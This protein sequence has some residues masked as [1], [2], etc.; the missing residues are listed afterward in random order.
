MPSADRPNGR[1][2][3]FVASVWGRLPQAMRGPAAMAIVDQ[4]VVSGVSFLTTIL[5]GRFTNPEQLGLYSLATSLV[6]GVL[7][8][9]TSLITM[10]FALGHHRAAGSD[11]AASR[12]YAGSTL[13]IQIALTGLVIVALLGAAVLADGPQV[14]LMWAM[15]L[16][17]PFLLLREFARRMAYAWLS[18]P[19]ALAIDLPVGLLQ[20][21]G[22]AAL[23]AIG[24]LSASG[25]MLVLGVASAVGVAI[26]ATQTRRQFLIRPVAF[27]SDLRRS[28]DFG[29]WVAGAQLLGVVNTQGTL[30]L[31][32][33]ISDT[34][35]AGVFA[36]CLAVVLLCN[37]L[38]LAVGNLLTPRA[39]QALARDGHAAMRRLIVRAAAALAAALG[40]FC[41]VLLLCGDWIMWR[42]YEGQ[43]YTGHTTLLVLLGLTFLLS[44]VGMA[45][46]DG[47]RAMG[48][49]D[50]EFASTL[51]D[52]LLTIALGAVGLLKFGL[53]GLGWAMLIGSVAAVAYQ[54]AAFVRIS[55]AQRGEHVRPIALAR[56]LPRFRQAERRLATLA[57]REKWSAARVAE[58]Q[59]RLLNDLWA[60]AS[61]NVPY[62]RELAAA[63]RL[64]P[65]FNSIEHFKAVVPLVEKDPCA[66]GLTIS[67][68]RAHRPV[69]G[70]QRPAR[71]ARRCVSTRRT[72]PTRRC[73]PASIASASCGTS[74]CSTEPRSSAPARRDRR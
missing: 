46:N 15:L 52:T 50:L 73:S 59:L 12:S 9:Q 45:V 44:A 32:A 34:A 18:V 61:A 38:M 69:A 22:L 17:T 67:A 47:I 21:T 26:A 35:S 10:P 4:A 37:P 30:W 68:G 41:I 7:V 62:Y 40:L 27:Q 51:L 29:R 71:R 70:A 33:L 56:Y 1:Q 20:T 63:H 42:L 5:I 24:A 66:A 25:A 65:L 23:A 3:A 8:V 72:R 11:D 6:L 54:I 14:T 60:H 57:E 13:L 28:W 48:R 19:T 31:I 53:V 36:A 16:A 64:P 39:A 2:W 49:A 58:H 55:R 43:E 74:T